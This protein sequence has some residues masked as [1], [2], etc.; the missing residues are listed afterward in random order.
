MSWLPSE[1]TADVHSWRMWKLG[2]PVSPL[3]V[4]LET[5]TVIIHER[6]IMAKCITFKTTADRL[7]P[8]DHHQH[9]C[10][11]RQALD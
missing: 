10:F 8:S 9:V 6:D 3:E 1:E 11:A 4:I 2:Q 7:H 5:E